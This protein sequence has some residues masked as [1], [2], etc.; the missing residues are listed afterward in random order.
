[1]AP[2]G[3]LEL[4]LGVRNDPDWGPVVAL[5][6]GGVLAEALAD[7]RLM[8]PDLTADEIAIELGRLRAARLLGPFR[9]APARDVAAAA[10][11]VA[12]LGRFVLAHP[13]IAEIDINPLM[14]LA[15]GEGVLALDALIAVRTSGI[16]ATSPPSA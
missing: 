10:E 9:G 3:G 2:K 7:V 14:V 4:I 12:A 16:A 11:A 5:G 15:A 8:P 1:M 6:L 13:E